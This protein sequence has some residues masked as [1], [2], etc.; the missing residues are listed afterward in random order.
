MSPKEFRKYILNFTD[1]EIEYLL[2][3]K[4][5]SLFPKNTLRMGDNITGTIGYMF[6]GINLTEKNDLA[7]KPL[8]VSSGQQF[9]VNNFSLPFTDLLPGND[10]SGL[11]IKSLIESVKETMKTTK[12]ETAFLHFRSCGVMKRYDLELYEIGDTFIES[13]TDTSSFETLI[14]KI[15]ITEEWFKERE[16]IWVSLSFSTEGK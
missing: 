8:N 3:Q 4:F 14:Q 12:S 1:K 9:V 5:K 7:Q 15:K 13:K 6:N 2:A 11:G 10:F 16:Y